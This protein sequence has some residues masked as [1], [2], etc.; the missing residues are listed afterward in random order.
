MSSD[1]VILQH[2]TELIAHLFVDRSYD[3]LTGNHIKKF[4]RRPPA[5]AIG[6]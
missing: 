1:G 3:L 5:I 2:R 6:K 4:S